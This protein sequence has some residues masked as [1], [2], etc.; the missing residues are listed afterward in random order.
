[1]KASNILPSEYHSF[2]K[3]YFDQLGDLVLLSGLESNLEDSL[4]F[5]SRIPENK[6][7]Y[8]YL[9]D[10]WTIKDII[11]HL[12]DAE[13]VFAYRALRFSRQDQTNL[14]GFDEN[15]YAKTAQ[16]SNKEWKDLVEEFIWVRKSTISLFKGFDSKVLALTGNANGAEMSVRALGFVIIGHTKHHLSIISERYL[17]DHY[18]SSSSL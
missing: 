8:R 14:P 13:R 1:M 6:Y 5:F 12:I 11:Q 18:S 2:Y 16:A 15:G 17:N 7:D 9:Q 3:P 10:K 4:D